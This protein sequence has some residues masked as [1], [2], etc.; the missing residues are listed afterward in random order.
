MNAFKW[1]YSINVI[2][3]TCHIFIYLCVCR[4]VVEFGIDILRDAGLEACDQWS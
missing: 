2:D 1:T 3:M 4:L